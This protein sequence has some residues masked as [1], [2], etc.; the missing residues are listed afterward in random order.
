MGVIGDGLTI[1]IKVTP[2]N[3][4]SAWT[5]L[6]ITYTD[7]TPIGFL[8]MTN[9]WNLYVGNPFNADGAKLALRA[10]VNGNIGIGTT[11][12][13]EKLTVKGKIHAEEIKVDLSVPGPDWKFRR[14]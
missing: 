10:D 12:P 3:I 11:S 7:N 4:N 2:L 5:P 9:D 13:D 6:N 8:P 14:N 1:H